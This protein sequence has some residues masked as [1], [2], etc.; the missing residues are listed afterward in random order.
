MHK[1]RN[2]SNRSFVFLFIRSTTVKRSKIIKTNETPETVTMSILNTTNDQEPIVKTIENDDRLY[3]EVTVLDVESPDLFYVSF[4]D[5]PLTTQYNRLQKDLQ[6]FYTSHSQPNCDTELSK[7]VKCIVYHKHKKCLF[8]ACIIEANSEDYHVWLYDIAESIVVPNNEVWSMHKEIAHYPNFSYACHLAGIKPSGGT[9][10]WSLISIEYFKDIIATQDRIFVTKKGLIDV[11]RKSIPVIMLYLEYIDGGPLEK[12]KYNYVEI[13]TLLVNK[14]LAFKTI[15]KEE[16][17]MD[18]SNDELIPF[19]S[20]SNTITNHLNIDWNDLVTN[21]EQ[22]REVD[23]EDSIEEWPKSFEFKTMNF[24]AIATYVDHDGGI[25]LYDIKLQPV[26]DN[27]ESEMKLIFQN[28]PSELPDTKWNVG[29]LCTVR[30]FV[31]TNWYRGKVIRINNKNSLQ[32][33]MVDFGNDEECKYVDI[34]KKIVYTKIPTFSSKVYLHGLDKKSKWI[35]SDLDLLHSIIVDKQVH[36][37]IKKNY[38]GKNQTAY[39]FMNGE[40]VNNILLNQ[41]GMIN[42]SQEIIEIDDDTDTS[43]DVILENEV[44]MLP[45]SSC[46]N[47]MKILSN[48]IYVALPETDTFNI[49]IINVIKY[50]ELIVEILNCK[51]NNEQFQ[52]M[53]KEINEIGQTMAHLDNVRI[54]Q[55]CIALYDEDKKWYRAE[56]VQL[57]DDNRTI[58]VRFVDFGNYDGVPINNIR[59]IKSKWLE[60]PVEQY[61]AKLSNIELV[62]QSYVNE[63]FNYFET[64]YYKNKRAKVLSREPFCIDMYEPE[65]VDVLSYKSLLDRNLIRLK[66]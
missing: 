62:E 18:I 66:G 46:L 23:V 20:T 30:Y 15:C 49:T 22:R 43:T 16:S 3:K 56:I 32:V 52:M 51:I 2:F 65:D 50:N 14:G 12:S 29:D 54:G 8:R 1:F 64:L 10:K 21:D 4:N 61:V 47:S 7:D 11:E 34:R 53:S 9:N 17:K 26:L 25:F 38:N 24:D 55:V 39:I 63:V 45:L 44:D 42:S 35:T 28:T 33:L 6:A 37:Q 19:M 48:Y 36:V 60:V 40:N 27:M 41:N 31:N 13:N 5:K 59:Y 57:N 58:T